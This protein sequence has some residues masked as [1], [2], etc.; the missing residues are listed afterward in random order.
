MGRALKPKTPIAARLID[1]RG[2]RSRGDFAT[3]LDTKEGTY[4]AYERGVNAPSI[5]FLHQLV[6]KEKVNLHWFLTGDGEMYLPDEPPAQ[7][8]D[9][10]LMEIVVDTVSQHNAKTRAKLPPEKYWLVY[11]ICY[12]KLEEIKDK[13]PAPEARSKLREELLDLL[14]L[15]T[16]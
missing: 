9:A 14:K 2:S 11:M 12:R 7:L 6:R 1:L 3:Q 4:V 10:N 13:Y 16:P 15:A 8:L 5:E